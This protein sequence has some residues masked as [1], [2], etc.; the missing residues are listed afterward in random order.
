MKKPV[1]VLLLWLCVCCLIFG[2]VS[3]SKRRLFN[4]AAGTVGKRVP[5]GWIAD[6]DKFWKSLDIAVDREYTALEADRNIVN[7]AIVGCLFT[8]PN[9]RA[10]WLKEAYDTLMADRWKLIL[11]E[12]EGSWVLEKGT[13]LVVGLFGGS[14][15][16]D[17]SASVVFMPK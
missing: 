2:Q 13:M 3:S 1:M 4:E 12:G 6:G 7:K 8:D 9:I 14:G 15:N 16:G 10:R 11:D 17:L 5:S